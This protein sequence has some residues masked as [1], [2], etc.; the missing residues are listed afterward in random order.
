MDIENNSLNSNISSISEL[1]KDSD[2]TDTSV[3]SNKSVVNS[4]EV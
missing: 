4:I 3:D 1:S 2:E